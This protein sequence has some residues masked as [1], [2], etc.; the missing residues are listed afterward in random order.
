[1][2]PP[3]APKGTKGEWLTAPLLPPESAGIRGPIGLGF[4]VP[5]LVVSPF[6]RGGLVC[7]DTFDHTSTLRFL[8]TRFGAPVPN[9]SN[10]RRG[11]A[12]DLTSAFNFAAR[13][14]AA[15][16]SLAQ[17]GEPLTC[18]AGFPP[19]RPTPGPFPKQAKG[20]R[21]A[22]SGIVPARPRPP[23]GFGKG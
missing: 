23:S 14:N 19:V 9:L 17:P 11:V 4:R 6:S 2:R 1:M 12:G 8:E 20:K 5:M 15:S 7:R 16:P 3:T 10:W 18:P 22:P 21:R 13:P